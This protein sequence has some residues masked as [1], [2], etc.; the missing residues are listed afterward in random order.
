MEGFM[1]TASGRIAFR[2]LI[3]TLATLTM[4]G[5]TGAVAQEAALLPR[6]EIGAFGFGISQQAYPG[7]D[8]QLSRAV[9]LPYFVYRASASAIVGDQR[10]ADTFYG[11]APAFATSLRSAVRPM[12]TVHW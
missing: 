11:V 4:L 5:I 6:W 10:L 7:S 12:P 3:L 8:T 2:P 1:N 9:V